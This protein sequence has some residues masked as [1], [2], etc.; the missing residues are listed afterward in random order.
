MV[1]S[2]H[3]G[4][5]PETFPSR[6]HV[7]WL[8]V[9]KLS[10]VLVEIMASTSAVPEGHPGHHDVMRSSVFHVVNPQASSWSRDV[11]PSILD[12]FPEGAVHPV[13]FE[14]WLTQLRLSAEGDD[15]SVAQIPAVPL[16]DFYEGCLAGRD[17][18]RSALSSVA[19]ETSSAT[20][21][22]LGPLRKAWLQRWMTQWRLATGRNPGACARQNRQSWIPTI[23]F[24]Q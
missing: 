18:G 3:M 17:T 5:F 16:I 7:D 9:D 11:V 6:D 20:L 10:A 24:T 8:P 14:Q 21:R 19:A 15:A 13:P 1:S 23:M 22:E 2:A 12:E 4:M